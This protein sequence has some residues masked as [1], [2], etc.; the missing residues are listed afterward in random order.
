MV[1]IPRNAGERGVLAQ[2]PAVIVGL[3]K[4]A[5][6]ER[7][8]SEAERDRYRT[9]QRESVLTAFGRYNPDAMLV[10]GVD[11]GHTDPQWVLPSGGNLTVDGPG[12]RI[13]AH[14]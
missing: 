2:F 11:F 8:P 3:A 1:C 4:A 6:L 14:Y 7:S 13:T 5:H 12:R 10:F 9:D